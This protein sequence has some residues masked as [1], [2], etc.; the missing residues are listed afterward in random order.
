MCLHNI[1]VTRS[2]SKM[3]TMKKILTLLLVLSFATLAAPVYAQDFDSEEACAAAGNGKGFCMDTTGSVFTLDIEES[4][5]SRPIGLYADDD[6]CQRNQDTL[7]ICVGYINNSA[8]CAFK[9]NGPVDPDAEEEDSTDANSQLIIGTVKCESTK[10]QGGWGGVCK[11]PNLSL[12]GVWDACDDSGNN[13]ED[14][15][16]LC[17]LTAQWDPWEEQCC[18]PKGTGIQNPTS[19]NFD[20]RLLSESLCEAPVSEGGLGGKCEAYANENLGDTIGNIL[21]SQTTC[22]TTNEVVAAICEDGGL[23]LGSSDTENGCCVP[24]NGEYCASLEAVGGSCEGAGTGIAD[25]LSYGDYTLLERIPGADSDSGDL[26][27][28]LQN[29]YQAGLILVVLGAVFMIAVGGFTYMASAG[30]TSAIKKGEGDDN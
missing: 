18:V 1:I 16:G 11:S 25:T 13:E 14:Y 8:C 17:D 29:I 26:S 6:N 5:I 27:T 2:E 9:D 22:D 15:V 19:S 21:N 20:S 7:G 24:K 30:N 4:V 23:A 10:A 3:K 28:Y 12:D